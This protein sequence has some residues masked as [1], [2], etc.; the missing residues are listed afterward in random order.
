MSE[1]REIM[2]MK[3]HKGFIFFTAASIKDKL[4]SK[5]HRYAIV[6]LQLDLLSQWLIW[7]NVKSMKQVNNQRFVNSI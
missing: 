5:L 2:G 1:G 6:P 7:K 4:L 3:Q